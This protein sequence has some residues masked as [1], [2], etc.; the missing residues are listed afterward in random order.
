M[1]DRDLV[2]LIRR[3]WQANPT[4]GAP[5]IQA[6][7][8]KLGLNAST[9]TI[10]KYRPPH[11]MRD[12]SQAWTTFLANHLQNTA[13]FNLFVVPTLTF[14]LLFVCVILKHERRRVAH[15]NVTEAPSASWTARQV[16]NAFPFESALGILLRNR[17]GI[18]GSA[19]TR[20]LATLG[21]EDKRIAARSPWQSPYIER[22]IGSIRRECLDHVIILNRV[23]LHR[24]LNSYLSYCHD[25]R[26]HRA[27]D[28]DA[29]NARAVELPDSVKIAEFPM[30]GGLH[31]RYRRQAA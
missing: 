29:P 7:L 15:L 17:D 24:L 21:I 28:Q 4:W 16:L 2:A 10:R 1:I 9:S 30:V 14:R 25:S 27:L 3:M 22:L 23:H 5:R 13:A 8:A 31:H 19:F 11:P 6:E 20:C 26:T 18:Y 12:R